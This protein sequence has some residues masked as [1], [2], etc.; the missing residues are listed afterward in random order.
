M[1]VLDIIHKKKRGEELTRDEIKF[2]IDGF[3]R[4]DVPDYQMSAFAMAVCFT[5][6]T[7]DEVSYLT[8]AM[9]RSGDTLDLSML[10]DATVDKHSTGG[11]G[12]KTSLIV[13]PTVACLGG[14]VAKMSG[15]GLGHTGGT[16]D[17]LES[18]EG[19]M[20]T[21]P[22]D[23]FISQA[24]SVGVVIAGQSANLAPAD[25][26][27]Y[28]LRDVTATVDSIP[29]IASSIMSKKLAAGSKSIVLD[30]KVG[31]GA[32][33]KDLDEA[34]RLARTMVSIGKACGRRC[35]ALLTNMDVPLGNAVGNSL[36]VIEAAR[37]L[38]G[39]VKGDLR[40][41]CVALASNMAAMVNNTDVESA[42]GDVERV[43]DS[44]E[45]FEKMKEWVAAQGGN[46]AYLDDFSLFPKAPCVYE[47]E[48]D[49]DGF[50][51]KMD[52]E[53][54]GDASSILG[55]GRLKAGDAIDYS[56]GI[57]IFAKSGDRVKRGDVIAKLYTSDSSLIGSA[58][59]TLLGA[60]S[61][62]DVKPD[63]EKL[64]YKTVK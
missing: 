34:E 31:S 2:L 16:I 14:V 62:S 25:K 4:G 23:K 43:I 1:R 56:A 63:P 24:K 53:K 33:M 26:K 17:K 6:M 55:A 41:V 58:E 61:K 29:L 64:I 3:T 48:S 39:E 45:A 12:D 47:V 5:G 32:F 13:A 59:K 10:G 22:S 52:T 15:R 36:E 46:S 37:V 20:T 44:G 40:E 21:V 27:L 42:R 8:D 35:T 50:I 57:E 51:S 54:I 18:I 60:Y 38:K 19:F 49:F 7:D 30:V 28:A 11:V 9:M